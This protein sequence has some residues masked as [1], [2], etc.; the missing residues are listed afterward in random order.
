[1]T[2][3]VGNIV[4]DRVPEPEFRAFLQQLGVQPTRIRCASSLFL[5]R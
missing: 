3:F 4:R 2:L 5:N 1:V